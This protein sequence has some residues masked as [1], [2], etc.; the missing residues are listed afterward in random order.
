MSNVLVGKT[1][2]AIYLASDK[3]AI[4]FDV[5]GEEPVIARCDADC[6]SHT[7]IEHVELPALGTPFT[8]SAVSDLEL[9]ADLDTQDGELAFYGLKIV[10]DKGDMIVDYRNE[11]NGYYGGWLAWDDDRFY[12]GVHGQNLST[13]EWESLEGDV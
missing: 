1:V 3:M 11:S 4:K 12:G 2:T 10:T 13:E 7:W 5:A 6:C 9:N 8:V